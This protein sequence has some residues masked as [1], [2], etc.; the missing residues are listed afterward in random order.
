MK[1]LIYANKNVEKEKNNE[2]T[3]TAHLPHGLFARKNMLWLFLG[4]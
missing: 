2:H 1:P 3:I 4:L